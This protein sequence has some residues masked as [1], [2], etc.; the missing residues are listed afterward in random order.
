MASL[1]KSKLFKKWRANRNFDV[2]LNTFSPYRLEAHY[3]CSFDYVEIFDGSLNSSHLLG[4]ICNDTRQIFI[5]SYNRMTIH[6]RSDISFQNTGFLA[7]YNSFP[8]G[9]CTLD[10]AYEAWWIYP[11]AS[12]GASWFPKEINEGPQR[13]IAH[14]PS[15]STGCV[16]LKE[17]QALGKAAKGADWGVTPGLGSATNFPGDLVTLLAEPPF[18]VWR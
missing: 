16:S 8:S 17:G 3:N 13:C 1:V 7:W 18:S 11:A 12:L 4:K 9:K 2:D 10:H 14:S 15:L 5:S 6:F